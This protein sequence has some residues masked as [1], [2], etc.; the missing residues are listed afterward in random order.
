MSADFVGD[1]WPDCVDGSDEDDG[2]E[3][4]AAKLLMCVECAGVVLPAAQLCRASGRGDE[5]AECV[6]DAIGSGE[7]AACVEE[8]LG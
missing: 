3:E 4:S 7:C 6:R 2:D 5:G 8:Y 1:G